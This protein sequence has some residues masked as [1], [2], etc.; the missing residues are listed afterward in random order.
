MT[1]GGLI[2]LEMKMRDATVDNPF[3]KTSLDTVAIVM[4][5]AVRPMLSL[6]VLVVLRSQEPEATVVTRTYDHANLARL[7]NPLRVAFLKKMRAE[8]AGDDLLVLILLDA[9]DLILLNRLHPQAHLLEH[10]EETVASLP[11][12]VLEALVVNAARRRS[13][14]LT[15]SARQTGRNDG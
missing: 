10:P 15:T 6:K 13:K 4:I 9:I 3:A 7:K 14:L 8:S 11:T 1:R 5:H 2:D 12:T